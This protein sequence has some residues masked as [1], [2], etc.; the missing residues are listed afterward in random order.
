[1]LPYNRSVLKQ[2]PSCSSSRD[3]SHRKT[4]VE[5]RSSMDW[6]RWAEWSAKL[7]TVSRWFPDQLALWVARRKDRAAEVSSSLFTKIFQVNKSIRFPLPM[8]NL[9]YCHCCLI[10]GSSMN[11]P[12]S[13]HQM[14]CTRVRLLVTTKDF[15]RSVCFVNKEKHWW[16]WIPDLQ[17]SHHR[18]ARV[19]RLLWIF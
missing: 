2:L 12:V 18:Q 9:F 5:K 17:R 16:D 15:S 8:I 13:P 6:F 14:L 11:G 3:T 10:H 1:M 19:D 4:S 7:G